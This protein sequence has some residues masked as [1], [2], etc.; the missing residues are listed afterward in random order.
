MDTYVHL[1]FFF[2]L[3]LRHRITTVP[4]SLAYFRFMYFVLL[5]SDDILTGE[6]Q[7]E[8]PYTATQLMISSSRDSSARGDRVQA[9]N[10]GRVCHQLCEACRTT[11]QTADTQVNGL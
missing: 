2:S 3:S 10:V 1:F 6:E 5:R 7:E 11:S 4:Q 9:G 8:E